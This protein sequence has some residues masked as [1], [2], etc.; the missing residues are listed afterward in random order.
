MEV[1]NET[2]KDLFQNS[3]APLTILE[4][5]SKVVVGGLSEIIPRNLEHLMA[6]LLKGNSNRSQAFT[7]SNAES[8]RSHA[9][10]QIHVSQKSQ[11]GTKLATM[12]IIDLAG[13]H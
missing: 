8:S 7:C 13:I 1:Y 12:S 9:I 2:I 4:V 10:L 11:T 6:L 3:G 5:N